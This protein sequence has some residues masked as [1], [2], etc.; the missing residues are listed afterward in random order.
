MPISIVGD[1]WIAI[2]D[3]AIDMITMSSRPVSASA[4]EALKFGKH[5]INFI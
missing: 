2:D 5:L 3:P 1:E 4:N